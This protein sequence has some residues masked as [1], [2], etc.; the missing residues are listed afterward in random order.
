VKE[1][2]WIK[3]IS[4]YEKNRKEGRK[5]EREEGRKE[6]GKE[7][8]KVLVSSFSFSVWLLGFCGSCDFC[9]FCGFVAFAPFVFSA[10]W[11]LGFFAF[12]G[13]LLLAFCFSCPVWFLAV[14]CIQ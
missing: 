9:G 4:I 5:D 2:F 10:S 8:R 13:L 11:L 1:P 6:G 12:G 7:G 3:K 14:C